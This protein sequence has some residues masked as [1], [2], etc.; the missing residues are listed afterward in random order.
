MRTKKQIGVTLIFALLAYVLISAKGFSNDVDYI[1]FSLFILL[2]CW[3]S[4]T[5]Y[6]NKSK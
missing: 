4:Y 1:F 6:K 5:N 3:F 2:G